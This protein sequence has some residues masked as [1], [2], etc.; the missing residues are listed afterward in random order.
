MQ[1]DANNFQSKVNCFLRKMFCLKLA[2][3][4]TGIG[5]RKLFLLN[6]NLISDVNKCGNSIT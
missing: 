6:I 5:T 1:N 2:F 3:N 4:K